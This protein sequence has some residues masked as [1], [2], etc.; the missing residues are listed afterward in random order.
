MLNGLGEFECID[1]DRH[2]TTDAIIDSPRQPG[3]PSSL[4]CARDDKVFDVDR[5]GLRREETL[6]RVHRS[7]R[8]FH[9]RDLCDPR[10]VAFVDR[11]HP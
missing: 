7:D 1:Y 9:H 10:R 8:G 4:R 5:I 6:R 3:R 11:T 2:Q